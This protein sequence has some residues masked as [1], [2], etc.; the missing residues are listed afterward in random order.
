MH[1]INLRR[2]AAVPVVKVGRTFARGRR[3]T[4]GAP[5]RRSGRGRRRRTAPAAR[6]SPCRRPASRYSPM[7]STTSWVAAL[8]ARS[9][10]MYSAV[11]PNWRTRSSSS[12]REREVHDFVIVA[13]S[14]PTL[15]AVLLEHLRPCAVRLGRD[16]RR[17]SS[18]RRAGR[19]CAASPSRRRRRS[20]SGR[21]AC[22]GFGSQ[23]ASRSWKNSPSK[24][25]D[26]LGEEE[27]HALD[28]L[29]ELA[30]PLADGRER[31]AVRVV[32]ALVPAARRARARRGRPRAGRWS[33]S[34]FASTAG[35]RYPTRVHEA[36]ALH[37][38]WCSS[39]SAVC[40]ARLRGTGSPTSRSPSWIDASAA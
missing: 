6:G 24:F 5:R 34:T 12:P 10:P 26:L 4:R 25:G 13:G 19:R 40:V 7:R 20:T 1:T 28:R 17:G 33:R 14:R 9:A 2:G 39:A 36:P 38:A 27:P 30:Q 18:R 21:R 8:A 35:C 29:V 15:L 22:T 11:P 32:L 16:E 31:D 3:R 37:P 23:R